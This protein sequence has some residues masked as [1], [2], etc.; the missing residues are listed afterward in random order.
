MGSMKRI[1]INETAAKNEKML[2]R[3]KF[4]ATFS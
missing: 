3:S 4:I 1:T 2:M